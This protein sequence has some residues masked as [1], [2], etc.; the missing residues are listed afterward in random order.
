[1]CSFREHPIHFILLSHFLSKAKDNRFITDSLSI[2]INTEGVTINWS[3]L[4]QIN[5]F[6]V[7]T[8][9]PLLHSPLLNSL[10]VVTD[11][12]GNDGLV[13]L[14]PTLIFILILISN[15]SNWKENRKVKKCQKSKDMGQISDIRSHYIHKSV[16]FYITS[17]KAQTVSTPHWP[18]YYFYCFLPRYIEDS[19][20]SLY[21]QAK[22]T[23]GYAHDSTSTKSLHVL[24]IHFR[25]IER[26]EVPNNHN[27]LRNITRKNPT[28]RKQKVY[29]LRQHGTCKLGYLITKN[30][31]KLNIT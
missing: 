31:T 4:T 20:P 3:K 16:L 26:A 21:S 2:T 17:A 27:W 23:T 13:T 10:G 9:I 8:G 14:I 30:S 5:T 19:Q 12:I 24:K 25:L 15:V 11:H 18:Q 1:V 7:K 28:V 6:I 22:P 29:A